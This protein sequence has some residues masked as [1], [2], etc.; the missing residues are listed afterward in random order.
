MPPS[1]LVEDLHWIDAASEEF[2]DAMVDAITGTKMLLLFNFRLGYTM[3]WKQRGRCR[4]ID[5]AAAQSR[6]QAGELFTA[7][8]G[9][10]PSLALI[11][12]HVAERAS[13]NP[14]FIEELVRSLLDRGGIR[15]Q[16][17]RVSAC[18]RDRDH[19]AADV[20]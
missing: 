5:L 18:E 6:P 7:L 11:A 20:G 14:F 10:D 9:T 2:I 8:V 13:G 3:P 12:R 16:T 1:C 19:S 17:W 15:E 4:Q